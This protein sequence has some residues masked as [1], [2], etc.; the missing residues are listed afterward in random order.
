M[1][2]KFRNRLPDVGMLIAMILFI[3]MLPTLLLAT[4][5]FKIFPSKT[6]IKFKEDYAAWLRKHEG[7]EFFCYTSRRNSVDEVEKHIIPILESSIHVVKLI[8]K[9]TQ[10]NLND[11]FIS[12]SLYNL[13]H[14]GFPNL[15][16][17]VDGKMYDYSLHSPFY[18]LLNQCKLTE[19]PKLISNGL[20][21]LRGDI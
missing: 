3:L 14:V 16:K 11:Q 2:T 15:M 1:L 20:K 8:G 19:L 21:T 9:E 12:Y 5:I 17:V 7:E 18:G 10:T 4:F 13:K 6:D